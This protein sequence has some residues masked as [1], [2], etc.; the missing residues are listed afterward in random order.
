MTTCEEVSVTEKVAWPS[1]LV[2]PETV[3]M[4]DVPPLLWASVTVWPGIGVP[5]PSW[6]V[7]VTVEA[8][9]PLSATEVGLGVTIE[10]DCDTGPVPAPKVTWAV[11][12]DDE[13]GLGGVRRQCGSGRPL[14]GCRSP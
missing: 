12:G 8:D 13:V 7:T 3:V 4:T 10:L 9:V 14:S 5:E 6:R 11:L 1:A 2:T